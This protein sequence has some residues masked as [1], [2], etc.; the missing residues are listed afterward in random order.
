MPQPK[1]KDFLVQQWMSFFH[2]LP[3][4]KHLS[5]IVSSDKMIWKNVWRT[6]EKQI[7]GLL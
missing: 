4:K 3:T 1:K 5:L 2:T 7:C 6:S